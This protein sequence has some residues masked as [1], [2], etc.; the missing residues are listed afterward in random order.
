MR[1]TKAK[2]RTGKEAE[3][4]T[5]LPARHDEPAS[6]PRVVAVIPAYNEERYIGSVVL[7]ALRHASHVLVVDDGSGDATADVAAAAGAIV[8]RHETNQGKGVALADGFRQALQLDPHAVVTI[9]GDGQHL[10]RELQ[11]VAAPILQGQADIVVGSRYL[12]PKSIVPRHR[13]WGHRLFN[14]ITN[15][16]SRVSVT[17]SQSGFRA[18]SPR[19][20]RCLSFQSNSFSVE[21]EMQFV[22]REH[23][24][25]LLE[26]PITIHYHDK[27]KRP[28]LAHGLIVLNGI[29]RLMGQYRPLVFFGL[30][31]LL[32]AATGLGWGL[33]IVDIFR[34]TR[35][36]AVGY[37][38]I[39]VM[40]FVVGNISLTTGI[41]LHSIRGMFLQYFAGARVASL[42][43]V[44]S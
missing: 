1:D 40:L 5:A 15:A 11:A 2:G 6:A 14:L 18:F 35:Q 28:V 9:D 33:Y 22:A 24:L 25:R 34:R 7:K 30:P 42:G 12:Q 31:G 4:Q 41:I 36:L 3:A 29:L 38:F 27:P 44:D 32:L 19:A 16:A 8:V 39:C 13:V 20:L 23:G 17:D 21:S 26:V 43:E 10:P 37:A